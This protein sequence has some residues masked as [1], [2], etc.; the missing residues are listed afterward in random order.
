MMMATAAVVMVPVLPVGRVGFLSF[1]TCVHAGWRNIPER[2][3][4]VAKA[5]VDGPHS[6]VC[7]V[8]Q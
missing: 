5:I 2:L 7:D 6:A 3:N 4:E 1:S 8:G